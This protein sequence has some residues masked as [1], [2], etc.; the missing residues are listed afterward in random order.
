ME[1]GPVT[2]LFYTQTRTGFKCNLPS[3]FFFDMNL[4]SRLEHQLKIREPVL[5]QP[6]YLKDRTAS[7][8]F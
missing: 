5:A 6:I 4:K 7:Y 8:I 2:I 1:K 3:P